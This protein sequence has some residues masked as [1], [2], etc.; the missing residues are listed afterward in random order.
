LREDPVA[1]GA[2]APDGV[3]LDGEGVPGTERDE[4]LDDR[5]ET[6]LIELA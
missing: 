3:V 2:D 5:L 6:A 1:G 4:L